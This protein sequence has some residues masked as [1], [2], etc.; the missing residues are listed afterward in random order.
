MISEPT[1]IQT[2]DNLYFQGIKMIVHRDEEFL[3]KVKLCVQNPSRLEHE[4]IEINSDRYI[5]V[6]WE[7]VYRDDLQK[8]F[9]KRVFIGLIYLK[10]SSHS[11][12]LDLFHIWG[13]TSVE[14]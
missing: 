6:I 10:A 11:L 3:I 1:I 14:I 4:W 8:Y 2:V 13:N 7:I 12:I 5:V 9:T